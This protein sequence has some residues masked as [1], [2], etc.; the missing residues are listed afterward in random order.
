MQNAWHIDLSPRFCCHSMYSME[1]ITVKES[2]TLFCGMSVE[3][4]SICVVFEGLIADLRV[5]PF[6]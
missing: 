3:V 5:C 1:E 4:F 6:L 2:A